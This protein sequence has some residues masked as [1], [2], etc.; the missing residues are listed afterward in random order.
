M[1]AKMKKFLVRFLLVA[2]CVPA[3]ARINMTVLFMGAAMGLAGRAF[4]YIMST[5]KSA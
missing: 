2:A 5:P 3:L 1:Q 4:Y